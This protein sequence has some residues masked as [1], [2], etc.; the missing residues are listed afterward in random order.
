MLK[1][2]QLP[3]EGYEFEIISQMIKDPGLFLEAS[4]TPSANRTQ[5]QRDYIRLAAKI[6]DLVAEFKRETAFGA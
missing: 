2:H 5:L 6:P 3:R 1:K 4:N